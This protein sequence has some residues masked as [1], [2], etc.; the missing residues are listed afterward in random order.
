MITIWQMSATISYTD[1]TW[2]SSV[3]R[4]D[5]SGFYKTGPDISHFP[6]II[7]LVTRLGLVP[8]S[9]SNDGVNNV[10]FRFS[11][12]SVDGTI[13][14]LAED[15][16]LIVDPVSNTDLATVGAILAADTDFATEF[17][18]S[19]PVPEPEPVPVFLDNFLGS[20]NLVAHTP[21]IGSPWSI[22]GVGTYTLS[23]GLLV[24]GGGNFIRIAAANDVGK[25]NIDL[26]FNIQHSADFGSNM[27][28]G[29]NK[30]D[31]DNHWMLYHSPP[32]IGLIEKAAG[33]SSSLGTYGTHTGT[34]GYTSIALRIVT[35]GDNI[36][37]YRDGLLV[38]DRTITNRSS[39][40]ATG[41]D[42]EWIR[43]SGGTLN[44]DKVICY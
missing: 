37:V 7:D 24:L 44:I 33:V 19:L 25:A 11:F 21:D 18:G 5:G 38:I 12:F 6:E 1:G 42:F 13:T 35:L 31:E 15:N 23:G 32:V 40:T 10:V 34:F 30:A 43:S 29:F 20:G 17:V 41:I 9:T 28:I 14:I 2:S 39:K 27:N 26:T 36:K 3:Y 16:E 4:K 8:K 22:I